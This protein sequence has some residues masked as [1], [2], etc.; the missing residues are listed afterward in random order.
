V[1]DPTLFEKLTEAIE[2]VPAADLPLV[3]GKLAE[4]EALAQL[5][6]LIPPPPA[7]KASATWI[8]PEA[9]AKIAGLPTGTYVEARRSARRICEWAR[10]KGWASRPNK[11]TLR[12]NETVFRAWMAN[13]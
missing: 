4:L 8:T 3:I 6:L 7:P 12:V 13:K 5:R 9:A 11:R 10:G 2:S 1:L